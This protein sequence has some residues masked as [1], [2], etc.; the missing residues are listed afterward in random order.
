MANREV[1]SD[2]SARRQKMVH[3]AAA[4]LPGRDRHHSLPHLSPDRFSVL[5]DSAQPNASRLG[6]AGLAGCLPHGGARSELARVLFYYGAVYA[7]LRFS[8]RCFLGHDR[9]F[10]A[11]GAFSPAPATAAISAR[12]RAV[13][14][15]Y[16]VGRSAPVLSA[17]STTARLEKSGSGGQSVCG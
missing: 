1:G 13:H 7:A 5:F 6:R 16:R 3:L 11:A 15:E 8:R 9:C 2:E 10:G 17:L 14:L 12:D 4:G